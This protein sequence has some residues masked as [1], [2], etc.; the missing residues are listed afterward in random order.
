MQI[1]SVR[2]WRHPSE[3]LF[4][5]EARR[6][7]AEGRGDRRPFQT[8]ERAAAQVRCLPQG[9]P[10]VMMVYA[11]KIVQTPSELIMMGESQEPPRQFTWT[12]AAYQK[13]RT[14]RGWDIRS[15]NGINDTLVVQTTGLQ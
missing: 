12:G 8:S 7:A 9:V 2:R 14:L 15:E 13:I 4:R 1:R 5:N 10:G 11:F 6:G 3:R